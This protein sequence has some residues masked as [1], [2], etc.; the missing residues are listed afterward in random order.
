M[1]RHVL[2]F[3]CFQSVCYQCIFQECFFLDDPTS[4]RSVEDDLNFTSLIFDFIFAF[5]ANEWQIIRHFITLLSSH[6]YSADPSLWVI[7]TW[8]SARSASAAAPPLPREL[9]TQPGG[10]LET[11]NKWGWELIMIYILSHKSFSHLQSP[12][13]FMNIFHYQNP[14]LPIYIYKI[15]NTRV[16]KLYFYLHPRLDI[17]APCT[18]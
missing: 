7:L 10:G 13:M 1:P 15:R 5:A 4:D 8:P 6:L 2:Y 3:N 12:L 17:V 9:R 14:L 18:G 11:E 16:N